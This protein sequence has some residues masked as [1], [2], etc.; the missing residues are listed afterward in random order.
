MSHQ[1]GLMYQRDP[2]HTSCIGGRTVVTCR[3]C[4]GNAPRNS[5]CSSCNGRG[6]NVFIC[7]HCHPAAAAAAFKGCV[8]S[9]QGTTPNSSVPASPSSLSRSSST[10][11]SDTRHMGNERRSGDSDESS[12][13]GHIGAGTNPPRTV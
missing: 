2:G 10:L 8:G 12:S 5:V 11:S 13:G 3:S 6:F 4:A 1:S 9:S 7:P